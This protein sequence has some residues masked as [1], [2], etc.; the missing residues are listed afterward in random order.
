[1]KYEKVALGAIGYELP[2]NLVASSELER[3][4]GPVYEA[5]KFAP[6]QLEL[7]TG[8]RERRWWNP[9]F[10]LSEGAVRAGRK[11]L[12]KARVAPERLGALVY[13]GVCRDASEPATACSIADGIGVGADCAVYDVSNACLGVLSAIVDV[14]NRIELGQIEAGLVLSCESA[15][16]IN[17]SMIAEMLARRSLD[18]FR[19]SMATLTGGSGA[20]AVVLARADG[21]GPR[22]RGASVCAA[23]KHWDLCRWDRDSMRTD[24]AAVLKNGVELA[25]ATWKKFLT[26]LAWTPERV[27]KTICHQVGGQHREMVLSALDLSAAKDFATY[28]FLGNMGTVS[29]PLTAALAEERG[30]FNRGDKVGFLGIGSGLNCMMLGWEW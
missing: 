30:F 29:I 14:A 24:A 26:T 4:L 9:G 28:E 13:A 10:K 6:G 20:A 15:R 5:L 16:E 19:L 25:R 8:I 21:P 3:R 1:M 7:L 27:D 23:P 12:L 2:N 18:H 11:A 22:L 17:D